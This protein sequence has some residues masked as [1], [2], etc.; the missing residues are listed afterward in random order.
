MA[1]SRHSYR[2][3][4]GYCLIPALA[5]TTFGFDLGETSG[6]L[7]MREWLKDFGYYDQKLETYSMKTGDITCYNGVELGFIFIASLLAGYIGSA[8][9]RKKGLAICAVSSITGT[10]IQLIPHFWAMLL[11]R[12]IMG[13]AIGFSGVFAVSYWSEVAPVELR[14]LIVIL[15][16]LFINASQFLGACINEATYDFTSRWAYRAPLLV[17]WIFPLLLLML[18]WII[19]ESPRTSPVALRCAAQTNIK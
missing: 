13:M 16:Q 5:A 3:V 15:Y 2:T 1:V 6:F 19:P 8:L 4:I 11:G 10:A 7:A 17:S 14:G 9:G 18:V 12:A